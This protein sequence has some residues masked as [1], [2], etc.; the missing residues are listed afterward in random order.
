[1]NEVNKEF[2]V[3]IWWTCPEF[4]MDGEQ[5]QAIFADNGL[6]PEQDL[7]LP[8]RRKAVSRAV[9]SFQDRRRKNGRKVTE[10]AAESDSAVIY[11]ILS[12]RQVSDE[13]VGYNQSTKVRLDKESGRVEIDGAL[14]EDVQLAINKYAKAITDDDIRDFLRRIV[15]SC[16]GIP[17]RPSGGIYFIPERFIGVIE[18]ASEA[19]D[20]MNVGARLYVER[21]MDGAQER[22]IVWEAVE[23][24]ALAQLEQT[25][26]AVERIEKRVGS[27]KSQQAKLCEIDTLVDIYRNLLG[28][29]AQYE[30]LSERLSAA[31]DRVAEKLAELEEARDARK[32]AKEANKAGDGYK[33]SRIQYNVEAKAAEVLSETGPL[34]Y[35]DLAEEFR[36]R[37]LELR[38]TKTKSEAQW[39]AVQL[40]KA[41]REGD[42]LRVVS[43]GIYAAA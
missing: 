4:V 27:V 16:Y 14:A 20:A 39:L 5:A 36:Q 37:G 1:M 7:P 35:G 17:K 3:N 41:V 18:S 9:Y 33:R 43:R 40:A 22:E 28:Q 25:M 19:I 21:V 26:Q 38:A 2:G 10:K 12:Q 13:E 34:Y 11:G 31:S 23:D 24:N 15:R 42:K 32:A 6:E 8:S 30:D 29:E